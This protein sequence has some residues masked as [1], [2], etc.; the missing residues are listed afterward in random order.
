[1]KILTENAFWFLISFYERNINNN[2]IRNRVMYNRLLFYA[3]FFYIYGKR[4]NYIVK[5]KQ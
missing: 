3:L 5:K 1:M 2:N 4:D